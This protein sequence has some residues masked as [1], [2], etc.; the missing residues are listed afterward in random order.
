MLSLQ[1][2]YFSRQFFKAIFS[3][4][5]MYIPN[6]CLFLDKDIRIYNL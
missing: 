4:M 6:M 1:Q 3:N 5:Y 2:L